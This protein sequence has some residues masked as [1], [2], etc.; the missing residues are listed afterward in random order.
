M[1]DS[2][3]RRRRRL[4]ARYLAQAETK[5]LTG[6]AEIANMFNRIQYYRLSHKNRL[7][8]HIKKSNIYHLLTKIKELKK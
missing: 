6:R 5:P 3:K 7:L 4:K 2:L 8:R 1:K